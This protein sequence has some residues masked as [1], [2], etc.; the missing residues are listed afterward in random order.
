[1]LLFLNM[2][3][4]TLNSGGILSHVIKEN[5]LTC[6][7]YRCDSYSHDQTTIGIIWFADHTIY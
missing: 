2:L 4:K 1:M 5:K 7:G 3:R 6:I